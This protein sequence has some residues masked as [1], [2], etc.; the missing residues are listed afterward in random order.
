[1]IQLKLRRKELTVC[2]GKHRLLGVVLKP[3]YLKTT[4]RALM[5]LKYQKMRQLRLQ[6]YSLIT[7]MDFL[8]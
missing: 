1:M 4:A 2:S 6:P 8:L 5:R 7:L 3:I